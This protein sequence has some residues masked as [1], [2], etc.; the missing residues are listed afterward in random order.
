M[1]NLDPYRLEFRQHLVLG[2]VTQILV[3]FS[4]II[5]HIMPKYTNKFFYALPSEVTDADFS[6]FRILAY[7]SDALFI[8]SWVVA[9]V[10]NKAAIDGIDLDPEDETNDNEG[11]D[12]DTQAEEY[13]QE[14]ADE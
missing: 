8:I 13:G 4:W 2:V 7:L 12:R 9:S 11:E 1:R 14:E 10:Y 6:T 5:L 3:F